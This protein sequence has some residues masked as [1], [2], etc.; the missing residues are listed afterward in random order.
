MPSQHGY[1]VCLHPRQIPLKAR[2]FEIGRHLPCLRGGLGGLEEEVQ[3]VF[4]MSNTFFCSTGNVGD[5]DLIWLWSPWKKSF[6]IKEVMLASRLSGK[7]SQEVQHLSVWF[8]KKENCYLVWLY[9][10]FSVASYNSCFSNLG[11]SHF[12][13]EMDWRKRAR[14]WTDR[15]TARQID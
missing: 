12:V 7:V 4:I 11:L 10:F 1:V 2:L 13:Y 14:I 6:E 9:L 3:H 8:S 15:Q 5:R